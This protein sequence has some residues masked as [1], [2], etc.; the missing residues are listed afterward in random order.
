MAKKKASGRLYG[1]L[2][3]REVRDADAKIDPI[4]SFEDVADSEDEFHISRGKIFLEGTAGQERH[5]RRGKEG[6]ILELSDEE[7][8]AFSSQCEDSGGNSGGNSDSDSDAE[9]QPPPPKRTRRSTSSDA[10]SHGDENWRLGDWGASK[11]DYYNAD[12]IETEQDA[13]EE[14]AEARRLQE[15]RLQGMTEADFGIDENDWLDSGKVGEGQY[16]GKESGDRE[17]EVGVTTEVLPQ[18]EITE[19]MGAEER[20]RLL[21][22]RYPEFEPLGMEFIGLQSQHQDLGL[23]T[24]ATEA[25][26]K[27]KKSALGGRESGEAPDTIFSTVTIKYQ[28]LTAYLGALS[29]YFAL[30]TSTTCLNQGNT[31]AMAAGELREHAVMESLVTCRGLWERVRDLRVPGSSELA[32]VNGNELAVIGES[33]EHPLVANG[34]GTLSEPEANVERKR[35]ERGRNKA[36]RTAKA[37]QARAEAM[38]AE[39]VRKTEEGL[40]E[41]DVLTRLKPRKSASK[42]NIGLTHVGDD[43]DFGENTYLDVDEAAEKARRKKSLRFYTSQITQKSNRRDQAGNEAGG[44]VDLPYRERL[45]D[46]Q[47]RLNAEA[48]KRGKGRKSSKGDDFGIDSDDNDRKAARDLRL[49]NDEEYYN[50]TANS[51]LQRKSSRKDLHDAQVAAVKEG[52]I[53]RAERPIGPD[54]KR[55]IGYTIEKNKGLAPKRKKDVRNPRV[56]KRKK[57]EDKLKKLGS[58]R[59]VYK[60]GE[61]RGGYKGELTGI[62]TELVRSIKL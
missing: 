3:V 7:V 37:A 57:Y 56:K 50:L 46:R 24:T 43:S 6:E 16:N 19:D 59:Q 48:E 20:L 23:S 2:V 8:L 9:D 10:E 55:A 51:S 54:G 41:L 14:E 15:K 39:R 18:F 42:V 38:R 61:G 52:G 32:A 62:K 31:V 45:R 28:A 4:Q 22:R 26:A 29:M 40:A 47:A 58:I 12:M 27:H 34:G 17:E 44:D 5:R 33:E 1:G 60:G 36:L 25:M 21:R 30:L 49:D 53:I 35:G 13:A 11:Q